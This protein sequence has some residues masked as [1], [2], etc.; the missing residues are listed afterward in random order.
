ME[1]I[2]Q[3]DETFK[4]E[5]KEIRILG[6]YNEPFFVAKDICDVLGLSNITEALK[7]IPQKWKQIENLTSE[8]LK[9]GIMHQEQSRNMIILSEPAV[10]KLIMRSNKEIAQKFQEVVCEDILPSLRKKGEYKIQSILEKNKELEEE[11]F[12]IEKEKLQIEEENKRLEEEKKKTEEE[13]TK[14]TRKYVKPP[15]EKI[16]DKNVVYLMTAE[17]S[18]KVGE[19]VIGKAINLNNRQN[20]YNDGSKIFDFKVIYYISL[21]SAKLMDIVEA[22]VLMKL[23][24]YRSKAGRDVFLLPEPDISIFTNVFDECAKF[25]ENVHEDDVVYA[26]KT[27]TNEDSER[28]NANRKKVVEN[29]SK[30]K[31]EEIKAKEREYKIKNEEAFSELGKIIHNENREHYNKIS[32]EYYENNKEDVKQK[33]NE[34]YSNNKSFILEESKKRYDANK[35]GIKEVRKEYYDK[36]YK[37]KIATQRRKKEQCEC[38]LI[39]TH[40]R[41]KKHKKTKKHNILMEIKNN[42]QAEILDA[43]KKRCDCGM[44]ITLPCLQKHIKSNG[45]K[46]F[47]KLIEKMKKG[48]N[49]DS[50]DESESE[51]EDEESGEDEEDNEEEYEEKGEY[52]EE[53][54]EEN[55]SGND[56]EICECGFI[57]SSKCMRRHKKSKRHK[58]LMD[59]KLNDNKV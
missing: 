41:M 58:L 29:Y 43:G 54:G 53:K 25:Y 13:L 9:S 55:K 50:D 49:E 33:A 5:N 3:L 18:E 11:K 1:L 47:I 38:G 52:E 8:K 40:Y 6:S 48:E 23:A 19:Y 12:R 36:N 24:K 30:E 56:D 28:W 34:F 59:K 37:D 15:K 39:V 16:K 2:N 10:Y 27:K 22:A 21:E 32:N 26:K 42:N 17:E 14:L 45:H 46:M 44:I 35:D 31:K 57:L 7:N 4:F 20:N 51:N